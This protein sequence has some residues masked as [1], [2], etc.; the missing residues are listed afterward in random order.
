[1]S[2]EYPS[3]PEQAFNV[4]KTA[5]DIVRSYTR[6]EQLLVTEEVKKARIDICRGCN[7]FDEDA[8][9][10]N[11]CGCFLVNKVRFSGSKCPLHYW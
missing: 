9:R 11:E 2:E 7:W 3:L 6:G 4:S 8:M 5:F 10:C 1:M